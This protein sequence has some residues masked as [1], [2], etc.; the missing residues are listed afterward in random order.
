MI[1]PKDLKW[2]LDEVEKAIGAPPY[3]SGLRDPYRILVSTVLSARTKDEVTG[4]ASRRLFSK[5]RTIK[6]M[7]AIPQPRLEKLIYPVCFYR[8][9]SKA[10]K[11]MALVLEN[12]Y[13]GMVPDTINELVKLPGVG[14]KT[15]NLVVLLA[16]GKPGICVDTHV[17]RISNRWGLVETRDPLGTEMALREKVPKRLWSRINALL[18]P[19]GREVCKP[20]SPHCTGCPLSGKCPRIGVRW[21]R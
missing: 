8:N 15:A 5:V 6:D 19:F 3:V 12:D 4:A 20:V 18:V 14:R 13:N 10:L 9:K 17:H 7:Q 21:H 1:Q 16:F 11:E 2:A